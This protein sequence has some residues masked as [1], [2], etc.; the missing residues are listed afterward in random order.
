MEGE[1]MLQKGRIVIDSCARECMA[2]SSLMRNHRCSDDGVV[3]HSSHDAC[4]GSVT[5]RAAATLLQLVTV[6]EASALTATTL[7]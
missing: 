3:H 2:C 7:L 6:P 5:P 1:A 4:K